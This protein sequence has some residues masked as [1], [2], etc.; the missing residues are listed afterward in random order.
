MM[1][2][3]DRKKI[4]DI[5]ALTP[6][7]EG[8]LFHYLKDPEN[9]YYFEQLCLDISG[10]IDAEIFK[11]SWD[12]V[13][14][15]N[16]ML[17]A[18]FRWEKIENP[19]LLI[20]KEHQLQPAYYDLMDRGSASEK[21]LSFEEIKNR[22]RENKFDLRDVPFRVTLC[23]IEENK[24][25]VIIT[26][27]H[28]LYDGWSS[29]I[30]LEEFLKAY[31][32][33]FFKRKLIK[34]VK[35]GFKEFTRKIQNQDL[36]KQEYYWK[37]NL[38]GFDTFT[39]LP[40]KVKRSDI[41][42]T[43]GN[44]TYHMRLGEEIKEKIENQ[45]RKS[46][47]TLAAFIYSAWGILLQRYNNCGDVVF[48]TTVSGRREK[49]NGVE[50]IVGLFI[51]T[52]PLRVTNRPGETVEDFL[53]RVDHSL[54]AR[55]AHENTS[56]VNIKKYL[57]PDPGE[58]FFDTIVVMENYP[59]DSLLGS[60]DNHPQDHTGHPKSPISLNSYSMVEIT[61]Y[62]FSVGIS[63]IRDIKIDFYYN[64][65]EFEEESVARLAGHFD[66]ILE[67]MAN[68]PGKKV[69][70]LE[71]LSEEEKQQILLEF[72]HTGAN[73]P[74]DKAIH[75][76]FEEQVEKTPDH[77]A[78]IGLRP[79]ALG[80]ENR[81]PESASGKWGI[82]V[83]YRELD[84][85]ANRVADLLNKKDI[86]PNS[87]VAL[88]LERS[89]EMIAAILGVLK[90]GAGYLPI[91]PQYPAERIS[92]ILKDSRASVLLLEEKISKNIPVPFSTRESLNNGVQVTGKRAQ[93]KDFDT[94][95]I[96]DRSLVDYEK[97]HQFIGEALAKHTFT[98]QATRGC[99]FRCAFC[100]KIWPKNH[101]YRSAENI[102]HEV[103]TLY[104]AGARRFMFVDDI[105][106][107]EKENCRRFFELIIK[108][109]LKVQVFFANGLRGD[110]LTRDLIDLMVEA[111][112]VDFDFSLESASPR[113]QKLMQK[114]LNI[115]KLRQTIDYIITN[116]PHV[117]VELQTMLGFPTETEDEAMMTL[118]F[119]K[120]LKWIDFPYVHFLRI[121]PGTDM[122]KIAIENGISREAIE[123]SAD[124]AFHEYS[125]TLSLSEDFA[126]LYQNKYFYEYFLVKERFG[127]ILKKQ[128]KI[129]T[130][131]ELL[132]KYDSFFPTT[133]TSF[134]RLLEL[135]G[136]SK[137]ELKGV[138]FPAEDYMVV[139]EVN[140]KM[141]RIFPEKH[142]HKNA[143]RVLL[144]DLS[145]FFS[146]EAEMFY[147]VKEAP[148][149]LMYLL[150][151]LNRQYGNKINGKIAKSRMDFDSYKELRALIDD[152]EPDIIGVRTLNHYKDFFH[153]TVSLIRQWK[154]DVPIIAGGPYATGSYP[155]VLENRGVDIAV[156]GE[157]EITFSELIGK[158][159]ANNLK[160]P[161]EETLA[162]IKGIAFLKDG[163]K[164]KKKT[165]EID[166]QII[167]FEEIGEIKEADGPLD[168]EKGRNLE[169][170][171]GFSFSNLAY[172]IYTSGSTGKPRGVA[173]EHK[174]V[175]GYLNSFQRIFKVRDTDT[176]LQQASYSFDTFVE[177]VFPV[178]LSGGKLFI[179]PGEAILDIDLLTVLIERH[180]VSFISCSPLLL[181]QLSK[182]KTL[183]TIR[184]FISGGD[185]LKGE[186]IGGLL[187]SGSVYNTYGPTETTV[188]STYYECKRAS[189]I[190]TGI[191]IGKPISNYRTYIL[192]RNHRLL[193]VGIPGELCIA[194]VG[195]TR[196][197]LNNPELTAEKFDHD[198]WD[199]QDYHDE[200]QKL[201][202]GVQGGSFLEKS[203]PG[204]RRHY[205]TGDLG[206]WLPDGN[207]EFLGRIDHQVKIRG[208]RIEL[209]EIEK[210]L[211]GHPAV[212]EAVV[213]S[214][215]DDTGDNF[216]CAYVILLSRGKQ[217]ISHLRY[218]L[219]KKL[220]AYM[221]PAYFV[222]LERMPLTPTGKIDRKSLPHPEALSSKP[223]AA[224]GND[225]ESQLVGIWS[226]VLGIE[227]SQIGVNDNFFELGGHSLKVVGLIGRIHKKL[228]IKIA[229]SGI[230]GAP[231]V[232]ALAAYIG[233]IK[234]S[235]YDAIPPAEKKD[236][237]RLS[238]VQE[239]LYFLYRMTPHSIAYNMS[240]FMRLAGHVEA[241]KLEAV[242]QRLIA[243][244]ESLRTSFF[245][246]DEQP[247]QRIHGEET[248]NFQVSTYKL[249]ADD[250][251]PVKKIIE[252]FIQPFDLSRAPLLRV[253][254][255]TEGEREHI[256]VVD[257]HHIISD[258]VS[259][260][261]LTGEFA[262]LYG[263]ETLSAPRIQYRD[264]SEWQGSKTQQQ[265][266]KQEG[267]FW[268]KEFQE[269]IPVLHLPIDYLRPAVQSFEGSEIPFNIDPGQTRALK[270]LALREGTTLFMVLLSIYTLFL[271]KICNQEDIIIGTPVAGRRHTDLE[272]IIGMF[273][274]TL[275]MRNFP[276][277]EKTFKEF[278]GEVKNRAL[279]AFSHQD[280]PYADLVEKVV[281]ER[282]VSRN[283]LFDALFVQE[284][285]VSLAGGMEVK[286]RG[287]GS[288][289]IKPYPYENHTTKFDLGLAAVEIKDALH[290]KFEYCVKL[291]KEETILRFINYFKG[292]IST[293]PGQSLE[294]LSAIEIITEGEKFRILSEFNGTA[295]EFSRDKTIHRLFEEQV[296]RTPD[297]VVLVGEK[298]QNT[299]YKI[300]T[301]GAL[302]ADFDAFGV[303]QL[304]YKELNEKSDE[305]AGFLIEKG[306][307]PDTIV[308]IMME[309][310]LEMII[311]ILGILKAGGAYLP[312]DPGSPRERIDYMLKDSGAKILLTELPEGRGFHHSSNQF[313]IHHFT[314]LAYVI[315]TSGS[316]G[317]PKGAAVEHR[318]LN[319]LVSAFGQRVYKDY[320]GSL[321]VC[322]VSP[323]VFDASVKQIFPVLLLGHRL[324]IVPEEV[325]FDGS[326]LLEF[327][328]RYMI[329][330][331]DGTP[332]HIQ[333]LSNSQGENV[334]PVRVK[335]FLIGGEALSRES[336][337]A[338]FAGL[339]DM[340]ALLA[341]CYG[342]TE[343]CDV[344]HLYMVEREE[345][346]LYPY[347][348]IGKLLGNVKSYVLGHH[349]KLQP[350]GIP[351][352]LYI[353]GIGLARGYLNR[354]ELTGERFTVSPF[355]PGE[356]A[357]RTGDRV[358]WLPDGTI[359]YFGRIDQQVKIRGFRVELG[360][361]ENRL[362]A[363]EGVKEA[364]VLLKED[365]TGDNYLCAYIAVNN[366][367]GKGKNPGSADLRESLSRVLPAYMIPSSFINVDKMPLT[368]N[369]KVDRKALPES[370]PGTFAGDFAGP[371]D[372]TEMKLVEIWSELLGIR[373]EKI[374][375]HH[376]FFYLGGHS[377][378]AAL[379]AA[380][381]HKKFN[382][383]IPLLEIFRS[384]LL[385]DLAQY[386]KKKAPQ[387]Q[388]IS[389]APV[390]A[391]E[392]YD[393]SSAQKRLYILRQ[394]DPGSTV[395][396]IPAVMTLT[397]E[398]HRVKFER[399][400][401]KL[402][403]RHESLRTSFHMINE[404]PVQ[405]VHDKVNFEIEYYDFQSDSEISIVNLDN[406]IKN[407]VRPFNLEEA[408]LLRVRLIKA[409][410]QKHI[411]MIDM[412]HI[413][414]DG[415]SIGIFINEFMTLNAGKDPGPLR[416]RYRDWAEWQ[417][418]EKNS[419]KIKTQ[420]TYWLKEFESKI[421]VLNLPC[422]YTRS[423][424]QSFAGSR[425]T[426]VIPPTE[427]EHL[428]A[429]ALQEEVTLYMLLLSVYYVLLY[430]LTGQEDIVIGAPTAGRFQV[431]LQETIGMFLNTLAMRNSPAG[432][433]PFNIFLKEVRAKVLKAFE[434]QEYQFE[435]LVERLDV[436]RDTGRNPLFDV[437]FILQNQEKPEIRV[438]GLKLK[439]VEVEHT[440]TKFDLSLYAEET[441]RELLFIVTFSEKLFMPATIE[442][443]TDYYKTI[444]Y[445]VLKNPDQALSDINV[446]TGE[447]RAAILSQLHQDLENEIGPILGDSIFQ[448]RL[449]QSLSKFKD[450]IAVEYDGSS[451]SYA[452]LDRRS[453]VCCRWILNRGIPGSTFIG[454]LINHR[455]Q[456]IVT[457]LGIIK[458]GCVIV[459][460][461]P[462]YPTERLEEMIQVTG[463]R[464]IFIDEDNARR[465]KREPG[466]IDRYV[467]FIDP[468]RFDP[469][470]KKVRE[471]NK[472]AV[473]YNPE[474]PLYIHF[475]SGS[476]GKPKAILGKN[477][478]L[479]HFITW[480][481]ETLG[482]NRDF[483]AA[484]FTIPGFDPFLRDVFAPLLAGGGICI[485]AHEDIVHHSTHLAEWV[486][487]RRISLIHC[488]TGLFRLLISSVPPPT[489]F[490]NL[491]Y[492]L[493]AGEK[494]NPSDLVEWYEIFGE[495]VQLVNCYG[496]T[497]TTMSK[498]Y[499]FIK[500]R[501]INRE[502]IPIGKPLKGSRVIIL[503]ENR[504]LC[505]P[506]MPGEIC[507]RTPFGSCGYSNAPEL[508]RE[509]FIPDPFR[510]GPGDILYRSGD[511]GRVLADGNIDILG[512]ID[513]QVK[514]RGYRVEPGDIEHHLLKH[515]A[516][517]E[518]VV[519][520]SGDENMSS[521]L[522]AYIIP[523]SQFTITDLKQYL[524]QKLPDYMIPAYF[525][526]LEKIPLNPNGKVDR[527]ALPVPR[528]HTRETYEPPR[529]VSEEKLVSIWSE[530]LTGDKLHGSIGIYDNFF[531]LGGDS[532][533]ALQ[534]VSRVHKEFSIKLN[535]GDI[536]SYPR[537]IDLAALIK[538]TYS[539]G[540]EGI[541][542][543]PLQDHY[544]V[545]P[546]QNYLWHS[547]R[548]MS[549]STNSSYVY[550][551]LMP[552]DITILEKAIQSLI[553][554][555]E[556]LRTNIIGVNGVP[557]QIIHNK[558]NFDLEIYDYSNSKDI[559]QKIKEHY[560][561]LNMHPFNLAKD[562][563]FKLAVIKEHDEKWHII[564][565]IHHII[566]DIHSLQIFRN[567]LLGIYE[568][569]AQGKGNPLRPLRIQ[570]KDYAAYINKQLSNAAFTEYKKYWH[571][572]LKGKLPVIE[573]PKYRDYTYLL[574][575]SGN[576][577]RCKISQ[578]GLDSVNKLRLETKTTLFTIFYA[579]FNVLIGKI[580]NAK[581]IVVKVPISLR[582]HEDL[583]N[584]IGFFIN[585]LLIRTKV[586]ENESFINFLKDVN[587]N[588]TDAFKYYIYPIGQLVEELNL[589][590]DSNYD[591]LF[592]ITP[593]SFNMVNDRDNN[594]DVV[595][596]ETHLEAGNV[597]IRE[598]FRF[599]VNE[600]KN[601]LVYGCQYRNELF[602][603]KTIEMMM[604][605]YRQILNVVSTN[606][607]I[608]I[609]NIL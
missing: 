529:N 139:P 485:P 526:T 400:F 382:V 268:L 524:A 351:G 546:A 192:D 329:D 518:A 217:E 521:Y 592:F 265:K 134:S 525:V 306:V 74:W 307:Q 509:K 280:Y 406:I 373:E 150:T 94:L 542:P 314:N 440:T 369:G 401:K 200:N 424:V 413:I 99:P 574:K 236:Y 164:F 146:H 201:L 330:T 302:R 510:D 125:P 466:H 279:Q 389:I 305:L 30:I 562:I 6:M 261:W 402:I 346:A 24:Y 256:L 152:F 458:A 128:M 571:R 181:N 73:Y 497:E 264:F 141:K 513:R 591:K 450:N 117:I 446:I 274:N 296:E 27:H 276:D 161:D 85:R 520:V 130:E 50:E 262:A 348:P 23:K 315:Y 464:Y 438:P 169:H 409:E 101:V 158:V 118:D 18:V 156:L 178:L 112:T 390:E 333:L 378:K 20:L 341:N 544:E 575:K 535:P 403:H 374:S 122:E 396:N 480:E 473:L 377:L 292:L 456:L 419:E 441:N 3:I 42:K 479:L 502:R 337:S 439:P 358:R 240:G 157:G 519:L 68:H 168:K 184:T 275:P 481:I 533:K 145:Q 225:M 211:S 415:T 489:Y 339:G 43:D 385:K 129:L 121:F 270:R 505:A 603:A 588:I 147:D 570:V 224:P 123:R 153:R 434:N 422:D 111:G 21:E 563:L 78:L 155:E 136:I 539:P 372:G 552:L 227:G 476:T 263:G 600:Y 89:V 461:Y 516:V 199:Y 368:P 110:I 32:D 319:N 605:K 194:G 252:N 37:T 583:T 249:A 257:M 604:R 54:R 506:L 551:V 426:F 148:L 444:L 478:G 500:P 70:Q 7:Q 523:R 436:K 517:K 269:E 108:K 303:M 64:G 119:I 66:S 384:P 115:E 102:F 501:D 1:K 312:I 81:L 443:I 171:G 259:I 124:L 318:S 207:I 483:R 176:V 77:I 95:P 205:K 324:Y 608:K 448:T 45:A 57:G 204:R 499:Y 484:Q 69:H 60:I 514:I 180:R 46:K 469:G 47:V 593:L 238:S 527:K 565:V 195:V 116:H 380:R 572:M 474:D 344:T 295:A 283:P 576:A 383:S 218:Y 435:N 299:K 549:H 437:M 127:K 131:S 398:L 355:F 579:V 243:R 175:V 186:Y 498:V 266:L 187:S 213:T 414:S 44:C 504:N 228:N 237:Y 109:D 543:I 271:S 323:F 454:M 558:I 486:E 370:G 105:F 72:N 210:C 258:G 334:P 428:R 349:Q 29:G 53:G 335:L 361:I 606:P 277:G 160:L 316:T 467:E 13:I 222:I 457:L 5:F 166:R 354:P 493:L 55:E 206:C 61:D 281:T 308:G 36:E 491:E 8:M 537:I 404:K 420:E 114:N 352:E 421:P 528:L 359:E 291:F 79:L 581:D 376:N 143:L 431:E 212:G 460:L 321:N 26:N 342:P 248:I 357:Y 260:D 515:P 567:E 548:L 602:E 16:E 522:C 311:G 80:T 203:P 126:K 430:K 246:E 379:L 71:L 34:P 162:D 172:I 582:T 65:K 183:S 468:G 282:D 601:G 328:S 67:D 417:N 231:T 154:K 293:L 381:I 9:N 196:G 451:V 49:I 284:E 564:F 345:I 488:V 22:D 59:L 75:E 17:R 397:G 356:R 452:E 191:P 363:C 253:G 371:R 84:R 229:F 584:V 465:F 586:N 188:C 93:I 340:G 202:R 239:R 289:K 407:F 555:H 133:I 90:V 408:P 273:V 165:R 490:R 151:Y 234:E 138:R 76:L 561:K 399:I 33:L 142:P 38:E 432:R 82:Y 445:S 250:K 607:A 174:N 538:S 278:L 10:E 594:I 167:F 135:V 179:P 254:L 353:A 298:L 309:R 214:G 87:I 245:M 86:K 189:D 573:L 297:H 2:K 560:K 494:T 132:Q 412:N 247:V 459:P 442:I 338:F 540:N 232:Q 103:E 336:V 496:P 449:L 447:R 113:L 198:L 532:L 41:E 367:A 503:D 190:G 144:L 360:E 159:L 423:T 97:Y 512:R 327:Y 220:P 322:L 425:V 347:V 226:E 580:C 244:H 547:D 556:S 375:I 590:S 531:E 411:L 215:T 320:E 388:Y 19:L 332:A 288:F 511:L 410:T 550:P 107:L 235:R 15:T 51:N 223:Y 475:T 14:Q 545:S 386:I 197:Y 163:N 173:V 230:F 313:I 470:E 88:M 25:R 350:V 48:G 287:S 495:R 39:H 462:G 331:A 599:F 394:T 52:L 595:D 597:L 536:F 598:D 12:F 285:A 609:K 553:E 272:H 104:G 208:Y 557:R 482:V 216:I 534:V 185:V 453:D 149:G 585:H 365:E 290:F 366:E 100:H 530:I 267:D 317:R 11:R 221:V 120:S 294:K 477:R 92:F 62:D 472:G 304:T 35:T 427:T 392:Y 182:K 559:D 170:R 241:G 418:Q 310:S 393:L 56:L 487:Q 300:Q 364:A 455:L 508:N 140:E 387:N 325:R 91:D 463:L 219:Q 98:I 4:E 177:E 255:I 492:I 31:N 569:F 429:L 343:C 209:G 63:M 596:F 405:K 554:R 193:P 587:A 96:P 58:A 40:I 471:D 233:K 362:L 589:Q 433:K 391:R 251:L 395:Y 106:N 286:G 568:A 28:I 578:G 83:T 242:F 137:E 326:Y 507:I 301:R 566:F 416:T 577:Y 541:E